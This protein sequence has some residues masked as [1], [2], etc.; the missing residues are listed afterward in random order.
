[1]K[2]PSSSK[3]ALA[4]SDQTPGSPFCMTQTSKS[5]NEA[6]LSS[7]R[8][9]ASAPFM[10]CSMRQLLLAQ[11]MTSQN[12]LPKASASLQWSCSKKRVEARRSTRSLSIPHSQ[13]AAFSSKSLSSRPITSRCSSAA[14][15]ARTRIVRLS[16]S[17]SDERTMIAV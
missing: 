15:W 3:T 4:L 2:R 16:Q 13:S 7:C 12:G 1:M 6:W 14:I 17:A 9:R 8:R 11:G 5:R 10:F